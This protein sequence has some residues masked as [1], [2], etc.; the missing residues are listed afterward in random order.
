MNDHKHT[1]WAKNYKIVQNSPNFLK[2]S[3]TVQNCQN[4]SNYSNIAQNGLKW[5]LIV[6]NYTKWF[7]LVQHVSTLSKNGPKQFKMVQNDPTFS[8]WS[9]MVQYCPTVQNGPKK[10]KMVF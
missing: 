7:K 6:Q 9:N 2:W 10:G 8:K 3:N 5:S 1:K 4:G